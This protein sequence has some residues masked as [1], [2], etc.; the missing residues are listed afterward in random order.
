M[1][2]HAPRHNGT[3]WRPGQSGNPSGR[4]KGEAEVQRLARR[5]SVDAI[6][7]LVEV[8]RL[9]T[10]ANP[11]AKVSAARELLAIGYPGLTKGQTADAAS[12]LH[13]HLTAI[14]TVH[15]GQP[16]P[17]LTGGPAAIEAEAE[18]ADDEGLIG[19]LKVL[20]EPDEGLPDEAL[21]L[22]E[23]WK[24][25]K[26]ARDRELSANSRGSEAVDDTI[27]ASV[28]EMTPGERGERDDDAAGR[29]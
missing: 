10:Y 21:P 13:L 12:A 2:G 3:S 8:A 25:A 29:A 16:N 27:T 9:P 5:Y 4:Q 6:K 11:A 1:S 18:D 14:Q 15:M 22:W 20:P 23:A 17:H 7:A 19:G 28:G 24:A 26:E